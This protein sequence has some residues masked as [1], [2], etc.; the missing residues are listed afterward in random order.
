MEIVRFKMTL[1]IESLVFKGYAAAFNLV[2]TYS[3]GDTSTKNN[4]LI[5]PSV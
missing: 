2:N 4:N 1:K 3:G 5:E